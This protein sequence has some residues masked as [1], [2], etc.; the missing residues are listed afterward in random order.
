MPPLSIETSR[1]RLRPFRA[2]DVEAF[3]EFVNDAEYLRYLGPGHPDAEGFIDHNLTAG[4]HDLGWVISLEDQVVGSV[5]LGVTDHDRLGEIAC[6]IDPRQAARGIGTEATAVVIRH[7][8]VDLDLAKVFA[9]ADADNVA[10]IRAMEKLGMQLEGRFRS[11]RI[12]RTGERADEVCYG[13][14]RA[15][16][17]AGSFG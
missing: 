2:S 17:E 4:E 14:T 16:W 13:L 9:R 8:F 1:L 7:A 3:V 6:L 15:D 12:R 5:F 11:H 10:S